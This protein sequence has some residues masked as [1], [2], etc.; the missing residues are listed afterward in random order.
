MHEEEETSPRTKTLGFVATWAVG[1]TLLCLVIGEGAQRF[2]DIAV[3][4][5]PQ[6]A[7]AQTKKPIFNA[8]DYASTGS[9][10]GQTVILSPCER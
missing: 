3:P 2:V 8:I 6:V 5:A 9:I 10:R 1:L 4:A 7:S